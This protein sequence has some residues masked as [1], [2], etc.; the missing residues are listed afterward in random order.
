MWPTVLALALMT[1]TEPLRF[2]IAIFLVSGPRPV[3]N[4]LGF[5]LGGMVTGIGAAT[6]VLV[7]LRDIASSAMVSIMS[8]AG[9]V[10]GNSICRHFQIAIGVIALA[11]AAIMA[12]KHT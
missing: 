11:I 3:A 7:V 6:L 4:L 8:T 5:W 2:G 10:F 1:A 9:N 12:G